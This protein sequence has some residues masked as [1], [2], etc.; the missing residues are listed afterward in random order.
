MAV[1]SCFVVVVVTVGVIVVVG[2]VSVVDLVV[3]VGAVVVCVD[4]VLGVVETKKKITLRPVTVTSR[5][6]TFRILSGTYTL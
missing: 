5:D 6:K 4:V 3:F 1:G 2:E